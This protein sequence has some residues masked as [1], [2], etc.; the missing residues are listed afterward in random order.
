MNITINAI[1]KKSLIKY[2]NNNKGIFK[3]ALEQ[4]AELKIQYQR[5]LPTYYIN[6]KGEYVFATKVFT[7]VSN[8]KST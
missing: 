8:I 4:L 6:D 5:E 1:D 3:K 7:E 2:L